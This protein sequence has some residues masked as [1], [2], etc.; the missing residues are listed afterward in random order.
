MKVSVIL[1]TYNHEKFITQALE[2]VL[3]QKTNFDYDIT[4]VED[5]S[6]DRTREIVIDYARKHPEKINLRLSPYNRND[7]FEWM[8]AIESARGEYIAL[9]DGDDYWTTPY[10]LQKQADFL[11]DTPGCSC[12]FHST[13]HFY[14]DGSREAY[15][16]KPPGERDYYFLE[17]LFLGDFIPTCATMFK[18]RLFGDFPGWFNDLWAGDFPVHILN[19][20]H[21]KIGYIN[22]VMGAT[23]IHQGGKWNG[24]EKIQQ[25]K[26]VIG[27]Y[28]ILRANLDVMN[29]P[30]V[31]NLIARSYH[32][33]AAEAVRAGDVKTA[34]R[35]L[36]K[37][38]QRSLLHAGIRNPE[39][40]KLLI[41]LFV[42]GLHSRLRR[43]SSAVAK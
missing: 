42:P 40:L 14:E 2:S 27:D 18:N 31:N 9:L 32:E 15:D 35:T 34:R 7:S 36:I 22:E 24:L 12:C 10:K 17:D 1:L 39:R 28:E 37:S 25:L 26:N 33:W 41:R 5:F 8:K 21:G 6:P 38:F 19:A 4:I 16:S 29:N 30:V 11:D 3:N 43:K 20:I 23:R 13:T